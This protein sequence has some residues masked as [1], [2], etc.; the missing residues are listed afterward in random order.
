MIGD[1]PELDVVIE[2]QKGRRLGIYIKDHAC[3]FSEIVQK[4]NGAST[5]L[6]VGDIIIKVNSKPIKRSRRVSRCII[7]S[8]PFVTLTIRRN[9][10]CLS[11][12]E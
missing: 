2:K 10:M 11:L 5:S 4:D 12:L 6:F 9:E 8:A 1:A 7:E 3:G